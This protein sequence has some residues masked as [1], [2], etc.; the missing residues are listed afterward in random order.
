VVGPL[1][2]M[3]DRIRAGVLMR[4]TLSLLFLTLSLCP[5]KLYGQSATQ[6]TAQE[7]T[8][9]GIDY[10]NA[11]ST[12]VIA[13][14]TIL[15]FVGAFR[16]IRTSKTIERAW[17]MAELQWDKDKWADAKAHVLHGR[18]S[19][20]GNVST[21]TA[22]YIQLVCKNEGNSPAWIEEKRMKFAI[23]SVL[24]DKPPLESADI[25]Q[26][27][28]EPLGIGKTDEPVTRQDAM[29]IA[30][31]Q[32]EDRQLSVIY[33]IVR[34]R[35]IFGKRRS[36]TFGYHITSSLELKRLEG[37]PAYNENT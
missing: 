4:R 23:F 31:G 16:Q 9:D 24:P 33:G 27:G 8:H 11:C 18:S 35:D 20:M 21:S 28:P 29:P 26:V 1:L 12:A 36:T 7:P 30:E 15:L 6:T 5:A 17:I 37:Y 2:F 25:I 32:A 13:V 10:I 14:F 34:Y 22:V 19:V 3:R